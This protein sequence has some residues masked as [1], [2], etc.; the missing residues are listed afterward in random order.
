[1]AMLDRGTGW[2]MWSIETAIPIMYFY[3][4]KSV[5]M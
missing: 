5:C 3:L 1:M 4:V 2:E